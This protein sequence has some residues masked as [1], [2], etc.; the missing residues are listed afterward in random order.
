[1]LRNIAKKIESRYNSQMHRAINEQ[2]LLRAR[3]RERLRLDEERDRFIS[4]DILG[5][6]ASFGEFS[7]DIPRR[8][9]G[10][11]QE[12]SEDREVGSKVRLDKNAS[13]GVSADLLP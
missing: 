13:P 6:Y 11:I 12:V 7:Q 5:G 8:S 4:E 10:L 1:M 2:I 9:Y 3:Q